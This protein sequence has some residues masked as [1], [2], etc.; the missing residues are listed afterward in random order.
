MPWPIELGLRARELGLCE[1][2]APLPRKRG[3]ALAILD[4]KPDLRS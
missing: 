3:E 1:A 4:R 2:D